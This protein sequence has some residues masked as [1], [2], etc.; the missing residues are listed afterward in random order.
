MNV[1]KTVYERLKTYKVWVDVDMDAPFQTDHENDIYRDSIMSNLEEMIINETRT[2]VVSP[3]PKQN[4]VIIEELGLSAEMK[5]MK[6]KEQSIS[7]N[8]YAENR[9]VFSSIVAGCGMAEGIT[10]ETILIFQ[11]GKLNFKAE[12]GYRNNLPL[13]DVI[14][15]QLFESKVCLTSQRKGKNTYFV[16]RNVG[17]NFVYNCFS[18]PT[19]RFEYGKHEDANAKDFFIIYW[20]DGGCVETQTNAAGEAYGKMKCFDKNKKLIFDGKAPIG[21]P[22][23]KYEL[24]GHSEINVFLRRFYDNNVSKN[25]DKKEKADNKA[26]ADNKEKGEDEEQQQAKKRRVEEDKKLEKALKEE[27]ELKDSHIKVAPI[28]KDV[29]AMTEAEAKEH[30]TSLNLSAKKLK[31]KMRPWRADQPATPSSSSSKKRKR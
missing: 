16:Q 14:E 17:D 3:G 7:V 21:M 20:R 15:Q 23:Q 29:N 27:K 8:K 24:D 5:R 13:E 6:K 26:A 30:Y 10:H 28:L 18:V 19:K 25:A 31:E 12:G 1:A 4:G 2:L 9:F 11:D 22:I